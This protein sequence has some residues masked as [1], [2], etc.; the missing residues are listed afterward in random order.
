MKVHLKGSGVLVMSRSDKLRLSSRNPPLSKSR[1][2]KKRKREF[3]SRKHRQNITQAFMLCRNHGR[4]ESACF[5][6][7]SPHFK[8]DFPDSTEKNK[9]N[10]AQLPRTGKREEWGGHKYLWCQ[11]RTFVQFC[12]YFPQLIFKRLNDLYGQSWGATFVQCHPESL[13]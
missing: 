2:M 1:E 12:V 9:M 7:P 3:F 11:P 4:L 5:M 8:I 13:Y 6:S 10:H